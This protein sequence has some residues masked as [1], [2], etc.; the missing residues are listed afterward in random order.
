[1]GCMKDYK[2]A[3]LEALCDLHAEKPRPTWDEALV[4]LGNMGHPYWAVRNVNELNEVLLASGQLSTN[5][6]EEHWDEI[7]HGE[8]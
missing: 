2:I 4:R 5:L 1:M 7:W 8:E 6:I 3:A